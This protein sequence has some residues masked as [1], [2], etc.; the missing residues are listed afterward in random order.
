MYSFKRAILSIAA[1]GLVA[2][3]STAKT[4]IHEGAVQAAA[5][6][7]ALDTDTRA[8]IKAQ[9]K[10][11]ERRVSAIT[12]SINDTYYNRQQFVIS[13][14]TKAFAKSNAKT[15]VDALPGKITTYMKASMAAWN[16]QYDTYEKLRS[17]AAKQ[18]TA[19]ERKIELDRKKFQKLRSKF[20]A[21]SNPRKRKEM[22]KLLL[23]FAK[24][25][26]TQMKKADGG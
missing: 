14:S 10:L 15:K 1:L 17:D 26:K 2:A 12:E 21:L 3:C 19:A 20:I 8:L 24:E 22:I 23:A 6:T 18:F 4:E 16:K 11:H 5:M 7:S 25:V 13:E 9:D